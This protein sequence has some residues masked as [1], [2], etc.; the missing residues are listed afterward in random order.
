MLDQRRMCHSVF[1]AYAGSSSHPLVVHSLKL[2]EFFA[3]SPPLMFPFSQQFAPRLFN[4][5]CCTLFD[6]ETPMHSALLPWISRRLLSVAQAC[7]QSR[8]EY[9]IM[10]YK[11]PLGK[12]VSSKH[13]N[14]CTGL[15]VRTVANFLISSEPP[16]GQRLLRSDMLSASKLSLSGAVLGVGSRAVFTGL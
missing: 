5:D 8:S 6:S 14:V 2:V 9:A 12:S 10:P 13:L 16:N 7:A 3:L 1:H 15:Y 11:S 4:T